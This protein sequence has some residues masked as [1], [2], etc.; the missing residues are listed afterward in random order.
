M[1]NSILVIDDEPRDIHLLSDMLLAEGY[2]VFAALDGKQGFAR[3]LEH[4]PALILLDLN[5]P[6]LDGMGTVQLLKTDPR[7]VDIPVLFLTGS[8]VLQ[9]KLQ[10]FNMGA[11]DYITKPFSPQEVLARVRVHM[12]QALAPVA[13][14][15]TGVAGV[16]AQGVADGPAPNESSGQR[17]V[18]KAQALIAKHRAEPLNLTQL[19]HAV[20]TNE[21][22][23]TDEF[24]RHTG[25][26]V[27]EYQRKLR[28]QKACDLLL[29]SALPMGTIAQRVGYHSGAA[30]TYGFRQHCAMT[31]SEF[32]ASAGVLPAA[33]NAQAAENAAPLMHRTEPVTGAPCA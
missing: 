15:V 1:N 13:A 5:M 29:H 22:R 30:F 8:A 6:Q 14:G 17:L 16:A 28:H 9:D 23:L 19:A 20:G 7:L 10:A 4:R 31:P 11:A 24:R 33:G 25:L 12:R 3:A 27:F 26:A 2:Q 18:R 21:R 32:R